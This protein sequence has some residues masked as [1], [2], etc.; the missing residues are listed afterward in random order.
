MSLIDDLISV[1]NHY[2]ASA[3]FSGPEAGTSQPRSTA[4]CGSNPRGCPWPG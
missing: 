2:G 3:E 4:R 1:A